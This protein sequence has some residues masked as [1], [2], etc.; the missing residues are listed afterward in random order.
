[1]AYTALNEMKKSL[2]AKYKGVEMGPS[3]PAEIKTGQ[4]VDFKTA[5]KHFIHERCVDLRFDADIAKDEKR[6]GTFKGKSG[7]DSSPSFT[8]QAL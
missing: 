5:V 1:M 3:F 7:K 2:Q 8:L 4:K 6:A